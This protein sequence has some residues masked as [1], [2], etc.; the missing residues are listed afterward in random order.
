MERSIKM[1]DRSLEDEGNSHVVEEYFRVTRGLCKLLR[2]YF[3]CYITGE[4]ELIFL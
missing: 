2:K 4:E 1:T 3:N